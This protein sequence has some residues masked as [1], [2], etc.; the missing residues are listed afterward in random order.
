MLMCIG[1]CWCLGQG[2]CDWQVLGTGECL[3]LHSELLLALRTQQVSIW[4]SYQWLT[5]LKFFMWNTFLREAMNFT[6]EFFML[7]LAWFQ[8]ILCLQVLVLFT[9]IWFLQ[10]QMFPRAL[11]DNAGFLLAFK[12]VQNLRSH[13]LKVF[14]FLIE[15]LCWHLDPQTWSLSKA[16]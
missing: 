15:V 6:L 10:R 2:G 9:K 14:A 4:S 7:R 16:D 12:V 11:T 1:Y 8:G 5:E 13:C 3:N